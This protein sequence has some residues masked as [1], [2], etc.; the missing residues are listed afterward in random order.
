MRD[1]TLQ[2]ISLVGMLVLMQQWWAG[3]SV[4]E[5][6][7]VGSVACLTA[8]GL[9][10]LVDRVQRRYTRRATDPMTAS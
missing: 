7:I 2:I 4:F 3:A 5:T 9:L 1:F 6:L 8:A 10:H